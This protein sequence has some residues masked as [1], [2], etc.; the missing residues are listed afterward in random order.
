MARNQAVKTNMT[1]KLIAE[2]QK[3]GA[4]EAFIDAEHAIETV[5]AGKPAWKVAIMLVSTAGRTGSRRWKFFDGISETRIRL[6]AWIS[7]W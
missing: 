4:R 3:I 6:R 5:Y 2:A 7:S 1:C